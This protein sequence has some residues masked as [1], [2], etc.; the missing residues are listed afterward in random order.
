D[1]A[2]A[3]KRWRAAGVRAVLVDTAPRPAPGVR[4]LAEAM[5]AGYVALPRADS[6]AIDRAVRAAV[7]G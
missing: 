7:A 2:D 6:R 3:A 4:A 1:A 5:G